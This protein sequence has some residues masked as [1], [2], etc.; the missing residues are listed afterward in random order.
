MS[1]GGRNEVIKCAVELWGGSCVMIQAK[2]CRCVGRLWVGTCR[3]VVIG[4]SDG[5]APT[6][7]QLRADFEIE[8]AR[9]TSS[10]YCSLSE[11]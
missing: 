2:F 8:E 7:K 10:V 6:L 1:C 11:V 9:C 5:F 4:F 3:S